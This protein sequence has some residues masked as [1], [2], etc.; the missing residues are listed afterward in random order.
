MNLT[1]DQINAMSNEE[2]DRA[3]CKR[4]GLADDM[5]FDCYG[6]PRT[7]TA[8]YHSDT[9]LA[10]PLLCEINN[11]ERAVSI[12]MYPEELIVYRSNLDDGNIIFGHFPHT[13]TPASICAA[14]ARAWLAWKGM[15]G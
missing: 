15:E 2:L 14:I 1:I 8:P 6:N 3:I 11:D 5:W 7:G 9:D 13:N 12:D 10:L 4:K